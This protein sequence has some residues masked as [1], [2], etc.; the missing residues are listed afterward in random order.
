MYVRTVL[1][2]ERKLV[3]EQQVCPGEML[4]SYSRHGE[5]FPPRFRP[6]LPNLHHQ[7]YVCKFGFHAGRFKWRGLDLSLRSP[8]GIYNPVLKFWCSAGQVTTL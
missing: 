2:K 8:I 6:E 5:A 1:V 7:S 4:L 3:S